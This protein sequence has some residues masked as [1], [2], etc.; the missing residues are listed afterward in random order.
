MKV[1]IHS[2]RAGPNK[3]FLGRA[4]AEENLSPVGTSNTYPYITGYLQWLRDSGNL[5]NMTG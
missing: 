2:N 5:A 1:A 3:I 4:R